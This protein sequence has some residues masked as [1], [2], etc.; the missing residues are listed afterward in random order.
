[1]TLA[2]CGTSH[3][4]LAGLHDPPASDLADI[5]AAIDR[6]RTYV[7]HFDPDL[8]VLFGVDHLNGFLYTVMPQFCVGTRATA[9]GDYLS[10]AGPLAVAPEARAC[11]ESLL[12]A[13]IDVAVSADMTVDHAFA[14]PL[15]LLTGALDA[16]PVVPVF[17]NAAATPRSP[18][19]RSRVVGEAV[20]RWAGELDRRVLLI[21]SGGL[22]HDPPLPSLDGAPP[23]LAER[24]L[25]GITPEARR[26][27][28]RDVVRVA[29][30]FASGE[31]PLIPLSPSFDE[32]FLELI[33]TQRLAEVDG[34][35]DDW[36][37]ANFGR[38]VH[39]VR[40]WVAAFSALGAAGPYDIA[41]TFYRP[42]P[43]WL[44]GFGLMT[45]QPRLGG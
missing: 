44:V 13:G 45:A 39:E 6:A 24:L 34:W 16:V 42:V 3:S 23:E 21:G 15:Q 31:S 30:E 12:A 11:A 18:I 32:G 37:T 22:S 28:E 4:P 41:E 5:Q 33:R 14:Q 9:I 35:D 2:A 7:K 17:V 43:A 8:V 20:G 36:L 26:R 29:E 10:L 38:A 19:G 27:R 1:V 25:H 40:T